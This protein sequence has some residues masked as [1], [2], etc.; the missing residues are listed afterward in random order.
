[1]ASKNQP[2]VDQ[3]R[4]NAIRVP[5]SSHVKSSL[6][7]ILTKLDM[8]LSHPRILTAVALVTASLFATVCIKNQILGFPDAHT[9]GG[10]FWGGIISGTIYSVAVGLMFWRLQKA[11]QRHNAR[12]EHEKQFNALMMELVLLYLEKD[13]AALGKAIDLIPSTVTRREKEIKENTILSWIPHLKGVESIANCLVNFRITYNSCV[14]AAR[15]LDIV[16]ENAII[17][18][19]WARN[20]FLSQGPAAEHNR[21]A[22]HKFC[23]Q[24]LF[25]STD[26]YIT[27]NLGSDADNLWRPDILAAVRATPQVEEKAT[28]F[29]DA[30]KEMVTA[31]KKLENQ[32]FAHMSATSGITLPPP[33]AAHS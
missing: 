9:F 31:D 33:P 28:R 32:I 22:A 3:D 20:A 26:K 10:Q 11:D 29:R 1:M 21:G 7:R 30:Y 24:V 13:M 5:S 23:I 15:Q 2:G 12:K 16:V 8:L 19:T 6:R 14:D 4:G 25:G 18:L 27:E 17:D